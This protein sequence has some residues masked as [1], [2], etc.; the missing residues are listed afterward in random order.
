MLLFSRRKSQNVGLYRF[1][2]RKETDGN[3]KKIFNKILLVYKEGTK[4]CF[5]EYRK[6]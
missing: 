4:L 3:I 5:S 2:V 1:P 6:I